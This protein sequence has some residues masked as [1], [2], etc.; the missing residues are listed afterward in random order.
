MKMRKK[1]IKIF[2]LTLLF[3]IPETIH[4]AVHCEK[5]VIV[6]YLLTRVV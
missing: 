5:K 2:L 6:Q 1:K 3:F 4:T